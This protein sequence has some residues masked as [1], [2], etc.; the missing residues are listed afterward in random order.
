MTQTPSRPC[1]V[2]PCDVYFYEWW[3]LRIVE[4]YPAHEVPNA[5]LMMQISIKLL[6]KTNQL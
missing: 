5:W 6:Q 4:R 3:R 1:S 2:K